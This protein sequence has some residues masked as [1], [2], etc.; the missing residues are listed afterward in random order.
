MYHVCACPVWVL[1]CV[2]VRVRAGVQVSGGDSPEFELGEPTKW[3]LADRIAPT[4]P[5][6][7][8]KTQLHTY[9]HAC[10]YVY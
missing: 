6:P 9:V 10:V 2:Q 1:T 5:S 7:P 8:R 4:I 3:T